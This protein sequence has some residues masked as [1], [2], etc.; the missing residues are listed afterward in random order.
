MNSARIL[1]VDDERDFV[2]TVHDRLEHE[3]FTP[4]DAYDGNEALAAVAREK[5][6]CIILDIMMP[7][8]DGLQLFRHLRANPDTRRIPI[9]FVSVRWDF[10]ADPAINTDGRAKILRKPFDLA[11]LVRSVKESLAEA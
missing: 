11:T 9:I 2:M 6:D 5:P 10:F 8:M 7:G 4:I 1:I 3:G